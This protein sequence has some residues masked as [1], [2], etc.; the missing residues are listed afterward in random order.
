MRLRKSAAVLHG[1]S[2]S[3]KRLRRQQILFSALLDY[4]PI[5]SLKVWNTQ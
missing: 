1:K 2:R 5:A 3:V 4:C